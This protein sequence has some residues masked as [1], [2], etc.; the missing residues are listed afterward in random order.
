MFEKR[1]LKACKRLFK[2]HNA[3]GGTKWKMEHKLFFTLIFV[4]N[5]SSIIVQPVNNMPQIQCFTF[6]HI[7]YQNKIHRSFQNL[8][9]VKKKMA[10]KSKLCQKGKKLAFPNYRHLVTSPRNTT[11][12]FSITIRRFQTT[13]ATSIIVTHYSNGMEQDEAMETKT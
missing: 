2:Q 6:R 9:S 13:F 3:S 11:Q 10:L 8:P 1:V 7:I 4:Q 12:L 5:L